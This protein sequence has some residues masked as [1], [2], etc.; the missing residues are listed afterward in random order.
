MPVVDVICEHEPWEA[1]PGLLP[2][3]EQAVEAA[4]AASGVAL[5]PAAEVS[6]L[7]SD[8]ATIAGLNARWRGKA[9]PTNVL[10]FPSVEA[11]KLA[12]S[13]VVGDIILAYETC[14]REAVDESKTL[15]DHLTHLAVHG[16]LHLVGYDHEN[17]ADA[18]VMEALE[19]RVLAALG[20][21]DPYAD[22]VAAP[23]ARA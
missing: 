21:A 14:V 15:S 18:A 5:L 2:R 22:P 1:I 17:D 12:S 9:A 20:V 7:L 13:K 16:A 4:L 8:D 3:I 11:G 6:V 19:C 10:S 23:E